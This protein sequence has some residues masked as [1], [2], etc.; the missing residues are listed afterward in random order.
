MHVSVRVCVCVY[1]SG[2]E[3]ER[4]RELSEKQVHRLR[5]SLD[6][7]DLWTLSQLYLHPEY[8]IQNFTGKSSGWEDNKM[9]DY[10]LQNKLE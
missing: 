1:V 6:S 7:L 8:D 9:A 4:E 10:S 5:T 3:R 2:R